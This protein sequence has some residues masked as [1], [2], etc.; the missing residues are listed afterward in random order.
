[1]WIVKQKIEN[2]KKLIKKKKKKVATAGKLIWRLDIVLRAW[3]VYVGT[4]FEYSDR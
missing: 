2:K 1:M 3:F 4:L